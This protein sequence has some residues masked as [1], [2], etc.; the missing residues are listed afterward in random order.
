MD[1]EISQQ[2]IP[3]NNSRILKQYPVSPQPL[4]LMP[5]QFCHQQL[6]SSVIPPDK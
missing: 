5:L 1:A 2:E 3:L 6:T 4:V